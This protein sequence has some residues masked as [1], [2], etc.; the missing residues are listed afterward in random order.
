MDEEPTKWSYSD[1]LIGYCAGN[2]RRDYCASGGYCAHSECFCTNDTR[3][4]RSSFCPDACTTLVSESECAGAVIE[5]PQAVYECLNI[6]LMCSI[7]V[8]L[9][10][11]I[12]KRT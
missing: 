8:G 9:S 4:R 2:W 6:V 12:L 1:L 3:R 5:S 11:K 10:L 7:S